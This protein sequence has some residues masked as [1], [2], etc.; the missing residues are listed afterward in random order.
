MNALIPLLARHDTVF[1]DMDGVLC[2][3]TRAVVS[4]LF[5]RSDIR[6]EQYD[7][8]AHLGVTDDELWTAI[9]RAGERFWA[10]LPEFPWT[11]DLLRLLR[12]NHGRVVICTTP[13]RRPA[14]RHGKLEWLCDRGLG[15]HE[16]V[17]AP[18]GKHHYA[19]PGALLIDD[20]LDHAAAFAQRGGT[21]LLWRQPWSQAKDPDACRGVCSPNFHTFDP[22]GDDKLTDAVSGKE[23]TK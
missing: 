6:P 21:A 17:F 12:A 9:D 22:W 14:S 3:F 19:R 15:D 4:G 20:H 10:T 16:L 2:D 11:H 1:L 23:T 8:A 7:L 5:G 13:S 18:M